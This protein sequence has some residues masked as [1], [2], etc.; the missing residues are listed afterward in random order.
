[1]VL[2]YQCEALHIIN[3]AGIVYHPQLVAVYHQAADRCTLKRDEIQGRL[4][5]LDDMHHASRG[6]DMPSLR[7]PPKL[8]KLASGNPYCGLD[9]KFDRSQPVDFCLL[10]TKKIFLAFLRMTSNSCINHGEAVYIIKTKFC[11]SSIPQE[12]YI[13]IAKAQY[14]LRLMICAFGDD[15]HACRVMIYHCFRNG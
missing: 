9:K 14:S 5:D 10:T 13:I 12:L 8:G 15:I 3:S 4:A 7:E 6:D 1:M 2:F 11:I